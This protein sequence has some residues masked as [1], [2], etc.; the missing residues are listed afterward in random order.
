MKGESFDVFLDTTG[1]LSGIAVGGEVLE[2]RR[3]F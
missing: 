1:N 3:D 2:V